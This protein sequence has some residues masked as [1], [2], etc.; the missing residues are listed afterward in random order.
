MTV[1]KEVISI[2]VDNQANVLTRVAGLF[3]R[4]GFNIDSLTVSATNNPEISRITIV[5]EGDEVGLAQI[6]AHTEKLEVVR[7]IYPLDREESL[8][9]ELLLMKVKANEEN[10]SAIR[11]IVDIYRGRIVDLSKESMIIESTGAPEK[12]DGLMKMLEGYEILE[13]CRTG[14]T[15]I[16]RGWNK[17]P[18]VKA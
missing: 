2:F 9:R 3:G 16:L 17:E 15:G 1:K 4:R 6:L 8:F 7:G 12:I 11:E 10:R 5:F 14:V 18:P 13:V